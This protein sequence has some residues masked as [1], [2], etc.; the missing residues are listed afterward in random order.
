MRE[1]ECPREREKGQRDREIGIE[2]Y[3][4]GPTERGRD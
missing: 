4:V 2:T 3:E 1:R